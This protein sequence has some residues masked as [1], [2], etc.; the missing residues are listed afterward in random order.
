[1]KLAWSLIDLKAAAM[2]E[3]WVSEVNVSITE[4]GDVL[5][6]LDLMLERDSV[7]RASKATARLPWDG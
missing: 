6:R 5:E 3:G 1:L 4:P 7:R 2:L